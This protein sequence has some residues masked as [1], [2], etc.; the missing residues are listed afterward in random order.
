MTLKFTTL[1]LKGPGK[2]RVYECGNCEKLA[3]IPEP[4]GD[5]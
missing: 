2:M 5:A 4:R 3:F 1:R